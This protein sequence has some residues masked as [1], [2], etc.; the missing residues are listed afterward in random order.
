[1]NEGLIERW[2]N[3]VSKNNVIY[4]LGDLS[5]GRGN[6]TFEIVKRLNG[7]KRFILGNHDKWM[8]SWDEKECRW[9]PKD[10]FKHIADL[11]EWFLPFSYY[12]TKNEDGK[13]IVM[14]HFAMEVWHNNHKDAW[15]LVGH[16]HGNLNSGNM[17]RMDVGIDCHPNFEPFSYEE[18][19]NYMKDKTFIPVDHHGKDRND[20]GICA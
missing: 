9:K 3:K 5:F 17:R 11:F 1:M 10:K 8:I 12:E 16:S 18:V 14:C 4:I 6:Q 2:N 13:F 15:H 20:S 19:A 7:K